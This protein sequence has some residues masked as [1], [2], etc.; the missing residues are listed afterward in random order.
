MVRQ[1]LPHLPRKVRIPEPLDQEL[2]TYAEKVSAH[3]G[4]KEQDLREII[5]ILG[6]AA[7]TLNL[8]NDSYNAKLRGFTKELEAASKL[9]DLG[10]MR[11]RLAEQVAGLKVCVE[12]LFTEGQSSVGAMQMELKGFQA[13]LEQAERLASTDALTGLMNR[14]EAENKLREIIRSGET[15]CLIM[16]DLDRFKWI[17]DRE[18]VLF[19]AAYRPIHESAHREWVAGLA[20]RRDLVAFGI[21]MKGSGKLIGVCQLTGINGVSRSA[22]LQIRL[23][24]A[25][26]RG[27]GLGREAVQQ[28]VAFGFDDLNLHRIALQVFATNTRAIKTYEAAGFRH[29]GT[30]REAAFID[31]HFVDVRVMAMLEDESP[32]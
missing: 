16:L 13:R 17:N 22:D 31:G 24:V 32:A 25:T 27:K 11:R 20:G 3:F 6:E 28:L 10:Q 7:E 23:G 14:R 8:R 30:F 29:E 4:Q 9:D 1:V 26:S 2:R 12:S 18:L 21:R 5:V 15:F 19:N